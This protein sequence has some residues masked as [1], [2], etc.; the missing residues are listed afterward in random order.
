MI[1]TRIRFNAYVELPGG[2]RAQHVDVTSLD[3]F[4]M[5]ETGV[6]LIKGVNEELVPWERVLQ[7][8]GKVDQPPKETKK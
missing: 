6:H 7:V 1:V 5:D 4:A 3:S 8:R 2:Q